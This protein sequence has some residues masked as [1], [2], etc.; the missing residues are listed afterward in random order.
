MS[1]ERQQHREEEPRGQERAALARKL[2]RAM[3]L[4]LNG[5]DTIV[6]YARE[7]GRYKTPIPSGEELMKCVTWKLLYSDGRSKQYLATVCMPCPPKHPGTRDDP[8]KTEAQIALTYRDHEVQD[9]VITRVEQESQKRI[10]MLVGACI[11]VAAAVLW[12]HQRRTAATFNG[13]S[14]QEPTYDPNLVAPIIPSP[15]RSTND[16]FEQQLPQNHI[17]DIS[18]QFPQ[19]SLNEQTPSLRWLDSSGTGIEQV[20]R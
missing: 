14:Y 5:E 9:D 19:E 2:R 1:I 4:Q 13:A 7:I 12:D 8:Y 15:L 3:I 6:R 18:K 16:A 10:S 11:L 20:V 17:I